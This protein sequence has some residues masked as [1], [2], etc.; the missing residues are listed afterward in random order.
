MEEHTE[1]VEI[2]RRYV[3]GEIEEEPLL[4]LVQRL[5]LHSIHR[6]PETFE[7]GSEDFRRIGLREEDL[8]RPIRDHL[9]GRLPLLSLRSRIRRMAQIFS[10]EEYRSASVYRPLLAEALHLLWL[11]LDPDAPLHPELLRGFLP[12]VL[13]ALVRREPVPFSAVVG[14]ILRR[15][16]EFHFTRLSPL[17]LTRGAA[18][19]S[20]LW[21]DL[22]LL[23]RGSPRN[24]SVPG[25]QPAGG[26][27]AVWFIPF[28][29]ATRRFY[30]ED[31]PA[32]LGRDDDANPSWMRPEN[33]KIPRLLD[34]CPWLP[35][36]RY[37]PSY[38]IDPHGL[39][40]I[41]LDIPALNWEDL[42][43]AVQIFALYNGASSTT[44]DGERV[45]L[46]P[47]LSQID[48]FP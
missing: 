19:G 21:C 31:L 20:C 26:L 48:T 16:G 39:A 7:L 12:P 34:R 35:V 23:Y 33:S 4:G 10:A 45:E 37:R 13:A 29:V 40:E 24:G 18:D 25:G 14:G 11:V 5:D 3:K 27:A 41:V 15:L 43:F 42:A 46:E 28:S 2:I 30:N 38:L 1:A 47:S 8:I 9:A 17:E 32:R 22:A 6:L 36:K 44:L